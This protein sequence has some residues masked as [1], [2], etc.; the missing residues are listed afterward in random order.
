VPREGESPLYDLAYESRRRVTVIEVKSLPY[1]HA[2][3]QLRL[4][5]GQVLGYRYELRRRLRRPVRA[6][7]AVPVT[8]PIPWVDICRHA[9]VRLIWPTDLADQLHSR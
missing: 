4:G 9:D 6:I 8:A 3:S 7:V 5:L 1:D 2:V